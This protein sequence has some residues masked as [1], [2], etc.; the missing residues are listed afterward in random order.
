[1]LLFHEDP[2]M[3]PD[4]TAFAVA[5]AQGN[6]TNA[7]FSPIQIHIGKSFTLT[8]IGQTSGFTA[9]TAFS[10]APKVGSV[11]GGTQ[12]PNP[13][14]RGSSATYTITVNR[15]TGPGNSGGFNADLTITTTLPAGPTALF[16]PNPV[17]FS[18]TQNSRTS[19]L[20]IS[21]TSSTSAGPTGFTVKAER[22]AGDFATGNGTLIINKDTPVITWANPADIVYGTALSGTQ[23]NATADVAGTFAYTPPAGT[24][25][26]AG[27]GQ[28][29]RVDF[30]PT[31]TANYN[32]ASKDV[33]INVLKRSITVMADTKTKQ[34]GDA[35]PALTYQ[36]TSGSL[37]GGATF[38]G[39]L[40]RVAGE[41]VA[42]SPYAIQQGTL[43]L[44]TNY[45][46]NFLGANL[47]ITPKS[48]SVT[49]TA[50]SKTY[51]DADP[52]FTGTLSGFLAADGVTATYSRT[53][54]ETVAGSPA[55]IS[56][57]LSPAGVLP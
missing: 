34:Y 2:E 12:S 41:T 5:D 31:D 32:N 54:G 56:A 27:N 18:N 6:F 37:G 4:M 11:A 13:V 35:D 10:D 36:I 40:S 26:N 14:P 24:K 8:A 17:E 49:P 57:T 16:S 21:T 22:T 15:G 50:A 53:A 55:T 3:N 30:T 42:G 47:T 48:A 19:T 46:L 29:L 43:A 23:L 45:N 1:M 25:L 39:A 51:G 44:S 28:N 20:T 7:D 9:Q 38:S 33:T 52:T